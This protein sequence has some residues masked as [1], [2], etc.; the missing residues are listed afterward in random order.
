MSENPKLEVLVEELNKR[1]G[2]H[3][4]S[5][6][7]CHCGKVF[8]IRRCRLK[9]QVECSGCSCVRSG[10][11]RNIKVRSYKTIATELKYQLEKLQ[12]EINELKLSLEKAE[13]EIIS[14]GD[15]FNRVKEENDRLLLNELL[16]QT[17]SDEPKRL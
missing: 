9:K 1:Q 4:V 7:K 12:K 15:N 3:I 8:N 11:I 14:R 10:N 2:A 17:D 6:V 16:K 13:K 5:K